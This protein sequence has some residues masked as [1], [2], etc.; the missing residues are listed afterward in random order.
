MFRSSGTDGSRDESN[1]KRLQIEKKSV[2][3]FYRHVC[4]HELYWYTA[5]F[6]EGFIFG[7]GEG[8]ILRDL[9]R[10]GLITKKVLLCFKVDW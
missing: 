10:G 8:G 5:R 2:P 6:R 3:S 1:R 7:D 4:E 9:F